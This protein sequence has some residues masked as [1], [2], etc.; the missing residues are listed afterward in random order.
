MTAAATGSSTS[1][2]STTSCR[3]WPLA[4]RA[5]TASV[6]GVAPACGATTIA[7]RGSPPSETSG[8]SQTPAISGNQAGQTKALRPAWKGSSL[9]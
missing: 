4:I 8:C 5:R 1:Q 6:V 9:L 3:Q 2:P 7:P